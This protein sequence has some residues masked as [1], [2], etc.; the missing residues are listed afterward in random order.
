MHIRTA[1]PMQP[2]DALNPLA[3]RRPTGAGASQEAAVSQLWR[4]LL[5][6]PENGPQIG[7]DENFFEVGGTSLLA[8]LLLKRINAAFEKNL[9]IASVFEHTTIRSQAALL[10]GETPATPGAPSA[11]ESAPRP[12]ASSAS[13]SSAIAIIGVTGRFPG[14][15]SVEHFWQNL[16]DGVESITFFNDADPELALDPSER[17][18]AASARQN[19]QNYVAARPLLNHPDL[20]D[21]DF[22]GVYPKE[23]AQMD[24]QH[25]I[26]LE[27]AWELLERAGYAP[28]KIR[29][30]VGV[31]AG[32]SMNT[33][34]MRNLAAQPGDAARNFLQEFTGAYQVGNYATMMGNDKDFLPTRISYKL[35]LHGPSISVQSACSTALVAVAQAAQSLLTGQCEMALA[36]AVSVTFPLHRG[37]LAQEGGLASLDGHCRP[38]DAA[39]SGTV[40]GHGAGVVLLK[41]LD[42]ALADGDQV[43]AVLR[44]FALNN[45]GNMKVG[46]TAPSVEGQAQVIARAQKMAGVPTDSIT[47]LEAHGT[48]TPVGDPIEVAALTR[49][50]R[51]STDAQH[52]CSLGTAKSN[53]GHLD[54]AAGATGLIKTILQLQHRQI[55]GLLH[56]QSPNPELHLEGSPFFVDRELRTWDGHGYPLRAGVSAFG[57]GGTNAHLIVEE[58]PATLAST[59]GRETQLLLWS[60]KTPTSLDAITSSLAGHFAQHPETNLADAAYTL[61]TGRASH[62]LRRAAVVSSPEEASKIS[63][64]TGSSLIQNDHPFD[65]P[66]LV[67]AF[68]GQGVQMVHM[69][70]ELYESEPVFRQAFDACDAI[71]TP[72]LGE[73]LTSLVYPENLAD[74]ASREEAASR[75]NQ[76]LNAQPAIFSF[77]YALAQLWLSL[78]LQ[79]AAMIG[80]SVGEYVAATLSGVLTLTDALTLLTTRSRLMQSLPAGSMLAVRTDA[81]TVAALIAETSAELDLAAVNSPKLCVVS[82]THEAVDSFIA[83]LDARKIAHRRLVT[84]HAFHSRMLDPILDEF[85][86]AAA[87]IKFSAPQIPYV[88]SLTGAFITPE[89]VADP[90]YWVRHMRETVRFADAVRAV[91]SEPQTIL[92]EVGPGETLLQIMR[93]T[94]QE[95]S[96]AAK[97]DKNHAPQLVASLAGTAKKPGE[98]GVSDNR[99]IHTALG[100]LWAAGLDPDWRILHG[101]PSGAIRRRILLPTYV[102]D[103]KRHWVEPSA[104]PAAHIT[105][106]VLP[107]P[108]STQQT[109]TNISISAPVSLSAEELTM[110]T[111]EA[112]EALMLNDLKALITDLSG[113]DLEGAEP[114]ASFLELGFDSLFLTQLTQGVQS[115]YKVKLTLRQL[116]EDFATLGS[117]S[118][119]LEA[120]VPANLQPAKAA[121]AAAPLPAAVAPV[122][123]YPTAVNFA[124]A[125]FAPAPAIHA[126]PGSIEA[127]FASQMQAMNTLFQQQLSMLGGA[128]VA[129]QI[130]AP[131]PIA[132]PA[133]PAAAPAPA[134]IAP[135]PQSATAPAAAAEAKPSKPAFTPFRPLQKGESGGLNPVQD[136]YLK[137]LI[138]SYNRKTGYSKTF[139]QEHRNVFADGRVVSGFNLQWKEMVYPI[140]VEKA[141]GAYLWDK[142]GNRYID[143]LNGYGAILYGHSPDFILD[144]LR[145]QMEL[146]FPIGPQTDLVGEASEL[147]KEFTGMERVTFCNTGSEAVMGAMRLAR[148]VTG[149]NLIVLFAG[150]Y[151]GSFDEVLVKSVGNQRSMPVAPGIP[152]ESVANILVLDYGTPEALEIIRQRADEIAAVLVEP[153]QSRH[154]ELRPKEFLQE[155]RRITQQ[156]GS[157]L[158]FDEVVTGFRTHLGGM[159][160]VYGIKADLATYGKVVAGGMPMGILAGTPAYM[161]ALDGGQWKFGDQ[162]FP[163]V[164]VT[165]YAGTF[166]RHPLM[167][168]AVRASLRHLKASGHKLQSDLAA[169]VSALVADINALLTEF[170]YPSQLETYSS[171]F[172]FPVPPDPKL[173]RMLHFHLREQ[174]IHIQEGFPCFLTTA[175]T[176]ADLDEVRKAFRIGLEKM[177]AGQVLPSGAT[178][179]APSA[180]IAAAET[181]VLKGHDFSRANQA[182]QVGG[183]LAPEGNPP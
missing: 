56:Y 80:H 129:P 25:R 7:I 139:T 2:D 12:A 114:D 42:A 30:S 82:G 49:A 133:I 13:E 32:C 46:Y 123:A 5:G 113:T 48:G 158:I 14:A 120:T 100:R 130:I 115:K 126:A 146:G 109:L 112:N 176:D 69:G 50:F 179:D 163:E 144:A 61:Q 8:T 153:V 51:A 125:A 58:A 147:I 121:P 19:G 170:N 40:F 27:C 105:Q 9:P 124:P 111:P 145:D 38:F 26:F 53:V 117:L 137:E 149:R 162:S 89:T 37:Y 55:P 103:R 64:L 34:F 21:A 94:L 106:A 98:D 181:A 22:F 110:P 74:E 67:F 83:Q 152:R 78:G 11:R 128:A 173:A 17:A 183:A 131:Q 87:Q 77:E 148:T 135:A 155:V 157:A 86:Q 119:H 166:M 79:P 65:H 182:N 75:L 180:S 72:L 29:E 90:T 68:P 36:G 172:Y 141:K 62:K 45:D 54:V 3:S 96:S 15:D 43:L 134:K 18:I 177:R 70:K 44:G 165:F 93:Q 156:S 31:F 154:P 143:I 150:D 164:G 20:F 175:H 160:A 116:M 60:A 88:S 35:N 140:V 168:A 84:S 81:A 47:Y 174:G 161:D 85:A 71:L 159:Q 167:M 97:A 39:A 91:A 169:K 63:A 102:F 138:D 24:P 107:Y 73:S 99:A 104:T 33:Y 178:I 76:T 95:A 59:P 127:L 142:D 6:L 28:N 1:P 66:R 101:T 136:A 118:T 108:L 92:L 52:F 57:V 132:A 122:A 151:H 41:R 16:V 10:R 171:W 23:A 4:T